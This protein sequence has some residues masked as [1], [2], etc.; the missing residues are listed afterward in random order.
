MYIYVCTRVYLQ[1]YNGLS[2][3]KCIILKIMIYC[4]VV[5]M[6]IKTNLLVY[7]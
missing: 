1:A 2:L 5:Q 3:T 6:E 4:I 7:T